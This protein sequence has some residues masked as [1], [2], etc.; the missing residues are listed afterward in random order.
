MT[1]GTLTVVSI[2]ELLWDCFPDGR[3]PGG[4]PANVAFHAAQLGAE[5]LVVSRVGADGDG[6]ALKDHLARHGLSTRHVQEDAAHPTGTVS[7]RVDGQGHATYTIHEPVA[8]DGIE[9]DSSIAGISATRVVYCFGTLAQRALPSRATIQGMLRA[10]S[11]SFTICDINLRAPWY[12]REVVEQSLVLAQCAKLN[13][14]EVG[15]L[16]EMF[17]LTTST[18]SETAER[19]RRRFALQLVCVTRGAAGCLAAG[20]GGII[21]VPGKSVTVVDTVGAG[22]AFTAALACGLGWG[23]PLGVTMEL[24]NEVGALVAGRAGAMPS[25]APAYRALVAR[26]APA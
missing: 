4:A 2:G 19:L 1:A 9:H 15:V 22:D 23:W 26:L 25:L 5:G 7:V 20:E 6:A 21:E 17:G 11:A 13:E 3:R 18:I 12:T 24:A 16:C 8:W 10:A 14:S